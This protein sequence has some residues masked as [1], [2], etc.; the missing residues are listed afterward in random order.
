MPIGAELGGGLKPK[1]S[2][3][4]AS[5]YANLP[6]SGVLDNTFGII[7]A[8]AIPVGG[9]S[10][11]GKVPSS[12]MSTGDV[13]IIHGRDSS[14][15]FETFPGS[16]VYAAPISAYQYTGS[17]WTAVEAY[18]YQAS[19]WGTLW[20]YYY[21]TGTLGIITGFTNSG[22]GSFTVEAADLKLYV[23][24]GSNTTAKYHAFRFNESIDVTQFNKIKLSY[25]LTAN[26]TVIGYFYLNTTA[27]MPTST[28]LPTNTGVAGFASGSNVAEI[29]VSALAGNQFA[30]VMIGTQAVA[31]KITTL[32]AT[33]IWGE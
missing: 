6:S 11:R 25:N 4:R 13:V 9:F 27:S 16:G 1:F 21:K 28:S 14:H 15:S 29:N 32:Y 19:A 33:E 17:V 18:I 8:T 10:I 5:S 26:G 20:V 24:T 30:H 23:D 31:Y 22:T 3:V 12:G 2:Y 7:S